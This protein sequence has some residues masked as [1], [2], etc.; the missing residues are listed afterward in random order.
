MGNVIFLLILSLLGQTIGF[1]A[2]AARFPDSVEK[3]IIFR[4]DMARKMALLLGFEI[5]QESERLYPLGQQDTWAIALREHPRD[6]A[7]VSDKNRSNRI[8]YIPKP[9]PYLIMEGNWL[10]THTGPSPGNPRFMFNSPIIS[11]GS[12]QMEWARL[13][14]HL[15]AKGRIPKADGRYWEILFKED[16]ADQGN[17]LFSITVYRPRDKDVP[18]NRKGYFILMRSNDPQ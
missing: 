11:E 7:V 6:P 8:H 16:I 18:P 2:L 13:L 3:K 17:P 10:D 14:N 1:E 4:G 12:T 15:L 5:N 9:E